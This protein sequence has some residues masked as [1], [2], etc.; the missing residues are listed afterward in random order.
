MVGL[1]VTFTPETV[2]DFVQGEE[3]ITVGAGTYTAKKSIYEY[4]SSKDM[5][6]YKWYFTENV[7]GMFI[8]YDHALGNKS[9]SRGELKSFKNNYKTVRNKSYSSGKLVSLGYW[10]F[11]AVGGAGQQKAIAGSYTS[12]NT[13]YNRDASGCYLRGK[14]DLVQKLN[15]YVEDNPD[16]AFSKWQYSVVNGIVVPVLEGLDL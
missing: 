3:K 6:S 8:K 14:D 10:L 15:D 2:N 12:G 1:G 9:Y 13:W 7:P 16:D 5:I 11:D 4:G